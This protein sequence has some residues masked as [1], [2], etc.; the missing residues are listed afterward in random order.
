MMENQFNVIR[1]AR[2]L[3]HILASIQAKLKNNI[4]RPG[5]QRRMILRLIL[6]Y[7]IKD[8]TE[9]T[10]GQS[11]SKLYPREKARTLI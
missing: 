4:C 3:N 10:T 8:F 9:K 11:L 7:I 6:L 5:F 1:V 2:L